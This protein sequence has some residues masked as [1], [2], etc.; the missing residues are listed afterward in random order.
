MNDDANFVHMYVAHLRGIQAALALIPGANEAY[1][2]HY[3]AQ[4]KL[5]QQREKEQRTAIAA[6]D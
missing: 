4:L 2:E 1:R 3:D 6:A 5:C